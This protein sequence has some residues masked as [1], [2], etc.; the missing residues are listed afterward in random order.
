MRTRVGYAGGTKKYPTY[1]GLGDH[2]ETLQLDYDPRVITYEQLLEIFWMSHDP[3]E[4]TWS[5]QYMAIA[6][7]HNETQQMS[8][9]KTKEREAAARG[10]EIK[11][12][13]LPVDTFYMAEDYHQKH[14]L[15][16]DYDLIDEFRKMYPNFRDIVN[17]TAATRV[18][19]ILG[20][21][22]KI[23]VHSK[24]IDS[25]G[26][27]DRGRERLIGYLKATRK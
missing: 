24:E 20:A 7:F 4:R 15:Q 14:A 8:I 25:Y 1:H 21:Y 17:S 23:S 16:R 19:G 9:H 6:F 13:L 10:R 27:S 5:R 12:L 26:L 22:G 11:T 2:T 18:N 3:T